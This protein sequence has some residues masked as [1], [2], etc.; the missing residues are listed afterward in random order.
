M[1]KLADR[2]KKNRNYFAILI[3]VVVVLMIGWPVFKRPH[4]KPAVLPSS[5]SLSSLQ[6]N[7]DELDKTVWAEELAAQEHE[8]IFIH[9]WDNLRAASVKHKIF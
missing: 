9:L 3:G 5:V 4:L 6:E 2:T 8:R 1:A 7:R